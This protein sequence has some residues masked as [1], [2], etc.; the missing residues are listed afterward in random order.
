[1]LIIEQSA[2][3]RRW[4]EKLRDQAAKARIDARLVRLANGNPGDTRFVGG[5]VLELKID[6]GPGYR[7]YYARKGKIVLLLLAGGDKRT[8]DRDIAA[9]IVLAGMMKDDQ[10]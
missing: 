3:Y 2:T 4:F 9:A 1:M 10:K 5:G 7:I 6:Y 8:Q